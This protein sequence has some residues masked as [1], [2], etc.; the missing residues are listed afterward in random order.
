MYVRKKISD[1]ENSRSTVS[2]PLT[3]GLRETEIRLSTEG[4]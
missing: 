4:R 3:P 1:L 2:I